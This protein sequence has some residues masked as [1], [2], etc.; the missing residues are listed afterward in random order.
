MSLSLPLAHGIGQIQDL[1]IPRWLFYYAASL[2][3][4]LSFVALG[5]LWRK[6]RLSGRESGRPLSDPWQRVLL[7]PGWRLL[8][9]GIS[10]GLLVVVWLA[11]LV[12]KPDA[13]D[14][15]APVFIWVVFWLGLVPLVVIFGNLWSVL[16]PWKAGADAVAWVW[17]KAGR[18]WEP[19]AAYPERLGRW[20]AAALLLAF[21]TLELA[22]PRSAEPRTL[23]L[24]I[25]VYS[26]ITWAG[27]MIYGRRPWLENGEAFT[28]YF[29]LFSRISPFAVREEDGRR[30]V[31][32][33]PPLSGLAAGDSHPGT[34][35]FVAVMLGSVAFDGLSRATWWQDQL[36]ELEV[37]YIVESP[38]KADFVSLGF[39]FFGLLVAVAAIGVMYA[40]AVFAAKAIGHTDV[41][42]AGA[43]V[44]SL[45]PIALAY[46]IAHYFTLLAD[47]GQDAV[48]LASD[49]FG[50]GWDLFGTAD[51]RPAENLFSPNTIWY[52]QVGVLVTGHVL[53]L[54]LAHDRAISLYSSARTAVRTQYAMLAL[55]V[56]YTCT[57]LWL[58]SSG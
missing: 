30:R 41:P 31:V 50:K 38:T 33:R 40:L 49:P 18:S 17:R 51:F 56:L 5:V 10:F 28:V 32:V 52:V 21:A 39:N 2:T 1:P 9:G 13:G 57:G 58:L 6:P 35:A 23:A 14:N 7:W 55:M 3:L 29:G 54:V 34:V 26:W 19:A 11:A 27:M 4:I 47:A 22:W 43:F 12:G 53:G 25:V 45:V 24:A 44:G 42:L 37:R 20:P 48:Y 46:A 36:Y 16:N 8:F 15:I